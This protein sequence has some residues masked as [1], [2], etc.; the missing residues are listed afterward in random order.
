MTPAVKAFVEAAFAEYEQ[1]TAELENQVRLPA[2]QLKNFHLAE[3]SGP[4]QLQPPNA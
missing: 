4:A 3:L 2:D 1:R